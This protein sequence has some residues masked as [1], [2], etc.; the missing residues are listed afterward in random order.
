MRPFV[1]LHAMDNGGHIYIHMVLSYLYCYGTH[2]DAIVSC[3]GLVY[4]SVSNNKMYWSIDM[5][6]SI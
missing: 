6:I 2:L 5:N 1:T 4:R 3:W